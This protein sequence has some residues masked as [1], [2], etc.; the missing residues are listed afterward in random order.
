[1]G[2][3]NSFKNILFIM[4]KGRKYM[5]TE[6]NILIAFI[7]NFAFSIFEFIGGALTG[8]V[9][10]VSDAVHDAGDAVSIGIS[11]Y[12]E[13]KSK[14]KADDEYTY[15]YG[16]F[17]V[18]GGLITTAILI[19]GSAIVIYNSVVRIFNPTEINY[20]GM[21]IFAIVGV[22]VNLFATFITKDGD[23]LNQRAVNLHMLEDVLGWALVLV[24]AIIMRF[25][26]IKLID[27]I[28]SIG[29][30]IFILVNAFKNLGEIESIFLERTPS[31][32]KLEEIKEKVSALDGVEDIHHI[33]AWSM[34]GVNNYATMH[35]VTDKDAHEIKEEIRKKLK[36][37][38][39]GHVTLELESTCEHCHE[40]ECEKKH[41]GEVHHHHHHH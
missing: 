21:I 30:A 41:V 19:F 11:L 12:L 28:L 27:P 32:V 33:H 6:K 8:S 16:R 14:K 25:T 40:I 37:L 29:V 35:I 3:T 17:S 4:V 9:A 5:K 34:D 38:N 18:A 23:S 2:N 39:I 24:G 22:I 31:N 36:G 10:I 15:G 26:D 13:R 7:L 1:M 20:N